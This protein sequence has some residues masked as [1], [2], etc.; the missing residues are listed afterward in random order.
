M[1][2]ANKGKWVVSAESQILLRA[3]SCSRFVYT[4]LMPIFNLRK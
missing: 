3:F 1:A 2:K 4:E